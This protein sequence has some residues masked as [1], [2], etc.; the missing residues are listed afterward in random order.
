[1]N[2]MNQSNATKN[3]QQEKNNEQ[4]QNPVLKQPMNDE[5][6]TGGRLAG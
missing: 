3:G 5:L 6:E 2:T 4:I 1:M